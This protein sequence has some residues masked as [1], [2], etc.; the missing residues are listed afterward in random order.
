MNCLHTEEY[1][2]KRSRFIALLCA[3]ESEMAFK[4]IYQ[5]L[6][7]EH[8][9]ARH[10][11]R[12]GYFLNGFG[13]P[14]L[15]SSEDKE[16]VS[17]MK[18]LSSLMERKKTIGYAVFIVRYFGGTKLGASHLDRIYFALGTDLLKQLS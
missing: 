3:V 1:T 13:V 5:R 8:A 9:K 12:C 10:I 15:T 14:T 2:E 18:R 6:L 4:E 16:P 7:E 11:L 17:S